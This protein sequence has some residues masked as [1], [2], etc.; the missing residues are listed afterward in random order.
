MVNQQVAAELI[1]PYQQYVQ[2]NE[3]CKDKGDA[4]EIGLK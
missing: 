3:E 1:R 4:P 2:V